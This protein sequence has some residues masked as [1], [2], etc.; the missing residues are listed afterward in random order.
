MISRRRIVFVVG[1][2][3]FGVLGSIWG[4]SLIHNNENAINVI[5]TVFSILAGFLVAIFAILGDPAMLMAGSW[6]ITALQKDL[7]QKKMRRYQYLF[8]VYLATLG[9]ILLST[10]IS[11][12]YEDLNLVVE[13]IYLGLAIAGFL[14][15]MGLP[16]AIM[17]LHK[18][19]LNAEMEA[20]K[21]KRPGPS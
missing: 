21:A 15:S 2:I 9:L 12:K 14:L 7:L 4:R 8:Y 10:M 11:E 17:S 13:H 16:S 20:R 5:T 18:E 6:R 3:V 19:R 1:C